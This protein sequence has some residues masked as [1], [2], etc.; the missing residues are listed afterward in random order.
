MKYKLMLGDLKR[1]TNNVTNGNKEI[2]N[3]M[4]LNLIFFILYYLISFLPK[5]LIETNSAN[6]VMITAHG[7][8]GN[9]D[10]ILPVPVVVTACNASDTT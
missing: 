3:E 8:N 1:E 5:H 4:T 10:I 2:T 6:T 9:S 7:T